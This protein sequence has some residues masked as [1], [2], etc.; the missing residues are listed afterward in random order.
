M[1]SRSSFKNLAD[2]QATPSIKP[3]SLNVNLA[4]RIEACPIRPSCYNLLAAV[5]RNACVEKYVLLRPL[6]EIER[7]NSLF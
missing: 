5:P 1:R 6:C 3:T 2:Q 4:M 7:C